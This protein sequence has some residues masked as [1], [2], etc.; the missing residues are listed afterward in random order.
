M[1]RFPNLDRQAQYDHLRQLGVPPEVVDQITNAELVMKVNNIPALT[2]TI[3]LPDMKWPTPAPVNTVTSTITY[4][5]NID[6]SDYVVDI[7]AVTQRTEE[8]NHGL[9][10]QGGVITPEPEPKKKK[11]RKKRKRIPRT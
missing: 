6:L 3:L 1:A 9:L 10:S 5:G 2:L 11:L 7:G 4:N 8:G